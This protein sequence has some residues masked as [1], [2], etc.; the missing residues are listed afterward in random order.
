MSTFLHPR[1]FVASA[2]AAGGLIVTALSGVAGPDRATRARRGATA[3]SSLG[4]GLLAMSTAGCLITDP[5]QFTPQQHT[6]P[7]LVASTAAPD[8]REVV[9]VDAQNLVLQTFAADV[10]SQDDPAD[11]TGQFQQVHTRLYIDY[12]FAVAP[13]EPF[14]YVIDGDTIAAGT[15]DETTGRRVSATWQPAVYGVDPGCHTATLIASHVF[16]DQPGCPVCTD[17]Y[18]IL[19]WQ[20]LRCDSSIAGDCDELPV[21][22]P[23]ECP[24][25]TT[26]CATVESES[27]AGS[28]C[29]DLTDGGAT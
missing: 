19:S 10:I 13:G 9:I 28:S 25:I 29:P 26:S 12:G 1:C 22:G 15:L 11:S 8:L 16:D 17:D 2:P 6:A 27:D 23:G 3:W 5:P 4:L 14:R 20:L 24:P 18:S 7:F 21:S